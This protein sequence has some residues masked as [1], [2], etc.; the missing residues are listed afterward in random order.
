MIGEYEV[1]T[2]FLHHVYGLYSRI[3][4]AVCASRQKKAEIR[5]HGQRNVIY[6]IYEKCQEEREVV[7]FQNVYTLYT[8]DKI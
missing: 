8:C 1:Y 6:D 3:Q 7:C 2:L 4:G 5:G